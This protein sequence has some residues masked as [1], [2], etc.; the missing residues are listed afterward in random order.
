MKIKCE[1]CDSSLYKDGEH[2]ICEECGVKYTPDYVRNLI[3]SKNEPKELPIEEEKVIIE[4]VPVI[5]ETPVIETSEYIHC[6]C[7][8]GLNYN[9]AIYC[10]HC[11]LKLN[12]AVESVVEEP[13]EEEEIIPVVEAIEESVVEEIAAEVEEPVVEEVVEEIT[14]EVEESAVEEVIEEPVV[15]EVDET[16]IEEIV[17]VAEEC[18]AIVEKECEPKEEK[19]PKKLK[20]ILT[21][22]FTR[23]ENPTAGEKVLDVFSS[24]F[25]IKNVVLTFLLVCM[26]GY[27]LAINVITR[28]SYLGGLHATYS[29]FMFGIV[30]IIILTTFVLNILFLTVPKIKKSGFFAKFVIAFNFIS[31]NIAL[32][33]VVDP[34]NGLVPAFRNSPLLF[35]EFLTTK[36]YNLAVALFLGKRYFFIY[37]YCRR[38][39][40]YKLVEDEKQTIW[41]RLVLTSLFL[42]F[43]VNYIRLITLYGYN[44]VKIS[45]SYLSMET[46]MSY[47]SIPDAVVTCYKSTLSS[48]NLL[49]VGIILFVI[50]MKKK[51]KPSLLSIAF[52]A[53]ESCVFI[54]G[55]L[56]NLVMGGFGLMNTSVG[57]LG[58][59]LLTFIFI[60]SAITFT[61][62]DKTI[63]SKKKI[64]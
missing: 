16:I 32:N 39:T 15:E 38:K 60:L 49:V 48:V 62:L 64:S 45:E 31:L 21:K 4:E 30:F 51:N 26:F 56:L 17:V 9:D 5:E 22:L 61:I 2:F 40:N 37:L 33:T 8:G 44:W 28:I 10:G 27:I 36:I 57:V 29:I 43:A 47:A 42:I 63:G 59:L 50:L 7:C 20:K 55:L 6:G 1:I 58:S 25:F 13:T 19:Q 41:S 53:F 34:R 3:K 12:S 24:I 14:N 18:K 52:M 46:A 54:L 23:S 35:R 11:G